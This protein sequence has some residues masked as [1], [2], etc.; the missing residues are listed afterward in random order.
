M[1]EMLLETS[2]RGHTCAVQVWERC[3]PL[4]VATYTYI[5]T[6]FSWNDGVCSSENYCCV[7]ADRA[8]VFSKFILPA[9]RRRGCQGQD[10]CLFFLPSYHTTA[11]WYSTSFFLSDFCEN[12]VAVLVIRSGGGNGGAEGQEQVDEGRA[13]PPQPALLQEDVDGEPAS[14]S[15]FPHKVIIYA[16]RRR[17]TRYAPQLKQLSAYV[18]LL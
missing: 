14:Q 17:G 2:H 5:F 7:H 10:V 8:N 18:D 6:L 13:L 4:V 3:C 1:Q 12:R 16:Y 9:S 15:C 11:V